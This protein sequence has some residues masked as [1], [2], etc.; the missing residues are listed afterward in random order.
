M[1]QLRCTLI[2]WSGREMGLRGKKTDL[3]D[4][5]LVILFLKTDLRSPEIGEGSLCPAPGGDMKIV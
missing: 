1:I 2:Q 5:L 4:Q 3:I